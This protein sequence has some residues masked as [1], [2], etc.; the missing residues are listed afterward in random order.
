MRMR[1]LIRIVEGEVVPFGRR[2]Q[3]AQKPQEAPRADEPLPGALGD[4]ASFLS[5]PG[6]THALYQ[7][8]DVLTYKGQIGTVFW[9]SPR[10][11]SVL[12]PW[13]PQ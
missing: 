4:L 11:R 8:G 3:H 1:D 9:P 12:R 7:R 10:S 2:Q 5:Q 13:P 6:P